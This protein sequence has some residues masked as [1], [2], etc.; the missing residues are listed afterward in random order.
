MRRADGSLSKWFGARNLRAHPEGLS[1]TTWTVP[2]STVSAASVTGLS[3][4]HALLLEGTSP[5]G[6]AI[7]RTAD[8]ALILHP[9]TSS[10]PD[11]I[12]RFIEARRSAGGPVADGEL[13]SLT[14]GYDASSV[15]LPGAALEAA[16]RD[17][18]RVVDGLAWGDITALEV[19]NVDGF[20]TWFTIVSSPVWVTGVLAVGVLGGSVAD[21]SVEAST[22]VSHA[23]NLSD[24]P[25]EAPLSD[26]D[27]HRSTV[28][29]RARSARLSPEGGTPVFS[30]SALR[31]AQFQPMAWAS[32]GGELTTG[33]SS[34]LLL[35]VGIR[36]WEVAEF[37]IGT[38]SWWADPFGLGANLPG[39]PLAP[40]PPRYLPYLI[41]YLHG[42]MDFDLEATRRVTLPLALDV[43]FGTGNVW[44]VRLQWGVR[45]RIVKGLFVGLHPFNPQFTSAQ[46]GGTSSR[47]FPSFLEVGSTF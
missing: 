47:S 36:A 33:R 23:E 20:M 6:A 29:G 42:G 41:V 32:L 1:L 14:A 8:G 19:K 22:D 31:K 40:G 16:T 10:I 34:N 2:F 17:G 15:S 28:L 7:E 13:W 27:V 18:I 37:G 43:G 39:V 3:P 38:N 26:L 30:D 45:V 11:W 12:R 9:G 5:Q 4:E 44:Q 25:D 35:G 21:L 46:V 24:S